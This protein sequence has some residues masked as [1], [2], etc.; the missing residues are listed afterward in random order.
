MIKLKSQH[1][2]VKLIIASI[3]LYSN[4]VDSQCL[5]WVSLCRHVSSQQPP[6]A[7]L[8]PTCQWCLHA[9]QQLRVAGL[10]SFIVTHLPRGLC[11]PR[12]CSSSLLCL[13]ER[14]RE[15]TCTCH[16]S[17]SSPAWRTDTKQTWD[18]H[19]WMRGAT[20]GKIMVCRMM[21]TDRLIIS[22]QE[23]MVWTA[24]LVLP[25]PLLLKHHYGFFLFLQTPL[26]L[27]VREETCTCHPS[28]SSPAWQN[29]HEMHVLTGQDLWYEK[30]EGQETA[31]V[32]QDSHSA[33]KVWTTEWTETTPG[34]TGSQGL[35]ACLHLCNLYNHNGVCRKRKKPRRRRRQN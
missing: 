31:A 24:T 20:E 28:C 35:L 23:E 22:E 19:L 30:Q 10:N 32:Y 4:C 17:C 8:H 21:S 13:P 3:L 33:N 11:C 2:I 6:S 15:R 7:C 9:Q 26:W 12:T 1:P 25:S 29:E 34:W 27:Y 18:Q 5:F 14:G 16:P